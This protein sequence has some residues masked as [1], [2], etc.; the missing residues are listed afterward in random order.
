MLNGKHYYEAFPD[1]KPMLSS[2]HALLKTLERLE[3]EFR[4]YI[5]QPAAGDTP[6]LA[7]NG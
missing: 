1:E 6:G 7:P 4:K 5:E 3:E 2:L